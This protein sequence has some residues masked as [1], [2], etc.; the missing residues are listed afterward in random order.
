MLRHVKM[1]LFDFLVGGEMMDADSLRKSN[2]ES[3]RPCT[4]HAF[5]HALVAKDACGKCVG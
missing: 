2:P 3:C 1:M 5:D 4:S